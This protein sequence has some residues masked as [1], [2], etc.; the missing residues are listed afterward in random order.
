MNLISN[1]EMNISNVTGIA[2]STIRFRLH[3]IGI[4][5]SRSESIRAAASKGKLG[6]GHRGKSRVFSEAHRNAISIARLE[7]AERTAKG[8]SKKPNGYIEVTRGEHKGRPQHRVIMEQ[9]IGRK[10][11]SSEHVHHIDGDKANN[12]IS[13][14]MLMTASEHM[15][16]HA[17]LNHKNRRRNQNGSW[18]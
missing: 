13:N 10:L 17:N 14:L 2:R 12:E 9:H 15:S 11:N 3:R 4:L 6:S 1:N 7:Y 16:Y 18:S 8:V 5:R